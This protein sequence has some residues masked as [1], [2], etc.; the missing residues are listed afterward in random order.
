MKK[1]KN[2]KIYIIVVG[3]FLVLNVLRVGIKSWI[4]NRSEEN[5]ARTESQITKE[6]EKKRKK[7]YEKYLHHKSDDTKKWR[8]KE[9]SIKDIKIAQKNPDGSYSGGATVQEIIN[10]FGKPSKTW[11][12]SESKGALKLMIWSDGMDAISYDCVEVTITN[13]TDYSKAQVVKVENKLI[14]QEED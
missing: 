6:Y 13:D 9:N 14:N 7:N 12:V 3:A 10:E 1:G 2:T 11:D 8:S 5:I 4:H